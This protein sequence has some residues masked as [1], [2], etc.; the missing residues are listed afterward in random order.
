MSKRRF[1][2]ECP[3]CTG[4]TASPLHLFLVN[5]TRNAAGPAGI[6]SVTAR[7]PVMTSPAARV[8][9]EAVTTRVGQ[10]VRVAGHHEVTFTFQHGQSCGAGLPAAT[11]AEK[12]RWRAGGTHPPADTVCIQQRS[13]AGSALPGCKLGTEDT[14]S[15]RREGE[16]DRTGGRE[17]YEHEEEKL[18]IATLG[19]DARYVVPDVS[20]KRDAF[21]FKGSRST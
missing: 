20:M 9:L 17:R 6:E 21:V 12:V 14:E 7:I 5:V 2:A 19:C 3:P 18:R 11:R 16:H 4:L 1:K 10:G 15:L 13:R 8:S